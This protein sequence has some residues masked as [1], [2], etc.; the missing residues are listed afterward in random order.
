[1]YGET[2]GTDGTGEKGGMRGT[3]DR[4]RSEVR[5]FWNFELRIGLFPPVSRGIVFR[6]L[7]GTENGVRNLFS[8]YADASGTSDE[9]VSM[10]KV[11]GTCSELMPL[12]VQ[13]PIRG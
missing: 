7:L 5:G 1:M 13:E 10:E 12:L 2:C 4:S 11:P 8:L 3:D 9:I 6:S